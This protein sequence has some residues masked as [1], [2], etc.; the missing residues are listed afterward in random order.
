ME[1]I[2][3]NLTGLTPL[4]FPLDLGNN[5]DLGLNPNPDLESAM[6]LMGVLTPE[7]NV[8]IN[9]IIAEFI[10][11]DSS[12]LDTV[13]QQ[14]EIQGFSSVKS[15]SSLL[16]RDF[17]IGNDT[18]DSFLVNEPSS[19]D[20]L[21]GASLAQ[22]SAAKEIVF[23]DPTVEDY[24]S[25]MAGVTPGAEVI[26]LDATRDGV[27][28]IS[29][30][31]AQH[32]DIS[33]VHIVSHGGPGSLQLGAAELSLDNLDNY[34]H[35]LQSW[36]DSLTAEADI[37]F[38]GCDLAAGAVGTAFVQQLSHLTGADIAASNDLTGSAALGGDWNLEE[39]TGTIES[40]VV[41]QNGVML[42]YGSV[43]A[44]FTG[45]QTINSAT[46]NEDVVISGDVVLN[47]TGDFTIGNIGK[48][49]GDGT[50][51]LDN[52]TLK[53][54]GAVTIGGL[55]GGGGLLDLAIEATTINILED[56]T[57]SSRQVLGNDFLNSNSIANSGD[58]T[59][60]A[61]T[62]TLGSGAQLLAQV[63]PGSG[64]QAG[65]INLNAR[66]EKNT[67][68][69]DNLLGEIFNSTTVEAGVEINSATLLGNNITID[70]QANLTTLAEGRSDD[71]AID[72]VR[73][74]ANAQAQ[75]AITGNSR[76]E[77]SGNLTIT[78]DSKVDAKAL[79]EAKASGD[80]ALDAAISLSDIEN[81]AIAQISGNTTLSTTGDLQLSAKTD[82]KVETTADG[83]AGGGNAAGATVAVAT[84]ETVTEAYIDDSVSITKAANIGVAATA[85]EDFDTKATSTAGGASENSTDTQQRLQ[86][87]NAATSDGDISV[88][89]AFAIA[90]TNRRTKAYVATNGAITTD[91]TLEID[92]TS[93]TDS[94][95]QADATATDKNIGVGVAVGINRVEGLNEA[96]LGGTGTITAQE[97]DI[98]SKS[99]D[100]PSK[101]STEA[102]SGA[103]DTNVG[104]AGSLAL[105]LVNNNQS[106]ALLKDGVTLNEDGAN[107]NL[108]AENKAIYTAKALP[109]PEDNNSSKVGVGASVAVNVANNQTRAEVEDG[110][111]LNQAKDLTLK[112]TSEQEMNTTAEAGAEG[113]IAINPMAA[114]SFSDSETTARIGT[115]N[116]LNVTGDLNL[117]ATYQGKVETTAKGDTAGQDVGIGAAFALTEANDTTNATIARAIATEGEINLT[118][119][120][121]TDSNTTAN[122]SAKGGK[123]KDQD[124]PE[125][126]VDQQTQQQRSFG[127]S[128]KGQN[129]TQQTS[130]P[131]AATSDGTVSVAAAVGVNLVNSQTQATI[132]DGAIVTAGEELTL[133][134]NRDTNS[135]VKADGSA[136]GNTKVG[137]GAAVAINQVESV[138]EASIG[139]NAEVTAQGIT[140]ESGMAGDLGSSHNYS[141]EAISGAGDANIGVAGSLALNL[142]DSNQSQALLKDGSVVNGNG[143]NVNLTAENKAI[144]TAKAL[145]KSGN[146]S[147]KVGVGA[148]AAINVANNQTRAEVEDGASLNQAQDLTL[149]ANSDQEMNTTAE[150][151]SE[152]GIAI[153]PVAALSF[154]DSETTARVGT[155]NG[156]ELTG[157]LNLDAIYKGK[158]E[159][160]AKGDTAGQDV[161][162][163]AAFA[164][165]EANDTTNAT[166]ERAI[167]TEGEI[168]LTAQSVTDSNTTANAS[169]KGGEAEEQ[170]TPKDGVD[171]QTEQQRSFGN[172]QKSQN[173]TQQTSAPSA[174]TSEGTVSVAAAVGVNLINSQ[175]QAT[176]ADNT[177]VTAGE[178]VTLKANSNTNSK[179]KADGSAGGNTK[180]G[181]GAAVAINQVESLNEASIGD[182]AEV[183]AQ[184]ITIESGVGSSHNFT[185]EAISG[186]GAKNVGVAG[187][188]ALNDSQSQSLADIGT[189]AIIDGGGADV[190]ITANNNSKTKVNATSKSSGNSAGIGASVALNFTDDLTQAS[191][192]TNAELNNVGTLNLTANSSDEAETTAAGGAEGGV[193]I[194]AS[195]AVA[196]LNQTTQAAIASG[197]QITTQNGV[198]VSSTNTSKNTTKADGEAAGEDIGIG[199]SV[200]VVTTDSNTNAI[201]DRGISTIAGDLE[202]AATATRTYETESQAS[203][204]GASSDSDQSQSK[205]G[206]SLSEYDA[207][208]SNGSVDLAAAVAIADIDDDVTARIS[209]G[210]FAIEGDINLS[211]TNQADFTT[212]GK[213]AAEG[214]SG[215]VKVA[216][217]VGIN[218]TDNQTNT[219]LGQNTIIAQAQDI[220][221]SAVSQQ[222]VS[223]EF[224]NKLAVEAIS[225]ASDADSVGVAGSLAIAR[226]KDE[227][228]A[229]ISDGVI[230]A[231]AEDIKVESS[232][233]SRLSAQATA[234]TTGSEVGIGASVAILDTDRVNQ[235]FLGNNTIVNAN[236]LSVT[237]T[238]HRISPDK[239]EFT[240]FNNLA[241]DLQQ[242]LRTNNYY[243][244]AIAGGVNTDGGSAQI[245]G[246]FAVNKL[247]NR[248]ETWIGAGS[249][250]NTTGDLSLASSNDIQ[251][252]AIAGNIAGNLGGDVS[253]G[254]GSAD[255]LNTAIT[256]SF[257][258]T[259]VSI[260]A[261]NI[262]VNASSEQDLAAFGISI[263]AATGTLGIAG[264]ATVVTANNIT[265][266]FIADS[267]IDQPTTLI[268]S[269][270]LNV[271]AHSSFDLVNVAGGAAGGGDAGVG[272]ST[273][274]SDIDNTTKAYLGAFT[275]ANIAHNTNIQ[276][277]HTD[278]I[279]AIAAGG[280]VGGTAGIAGSATVTLLDN[281]T[282]AYVGEN[283]QINIDRTAAND[284]QSVIIHAFDNTKILGIGGALAGGGSVGFGVGV[285]VGIIN[286]NTQ[287]FV[288]DAAYVA[289]ENNIIVDAQSQE[290]ITSISASFAVGGTAGIGASVG[291]SKINLTTEAYIG[292][293][294]TVEAEG[295]VVVSA[296]DQTEIDAFAGGAAG[297]GTA[298]I[299]ASVIVPIVNKT[300]QAFIGSDASVSAKG[301]KDSIQVKNGQF[302]LNFI[303]NS[304]D[305]QDVSAPGF[306]FSDSDQQSDSQALNQQRVATAQTQAIKGLAVTATNQ[307]DLESYAITGGI[308]GNVAVTLSGNVNVLNNNTLAYIGDRAVINGDNANAGNDQSVLVAAGNDLYH[309]GITGSAAGAGGVGV[310]P[311]A[312]V[313]VFS[314]NTHA[315]IGQSAQVKAQKDINVVAEA[316][317]EILSVG[318]GLGIGGLAGVAGTVSV[319][320]LDNSTHAYIDNDANVQANG[321]VLV[322]ATNHTETDVIAGAAGVGLGVG[323]GASVGVV[324]ID[325][326]TK[327]Y[328]G[329]GASVDGKANTNTLMPVFGDQ[330]KSGISMDLIKGVAVQAESSEDV[331]T[332]TAAGGGGLYVGVAGAAT[333]NIID[334]NTTAYIGENAQINQDTAGA[335]NTQTVNVS[336]V[337]DLKLLG[338]GGSVAFGAGAFAGG[339]D[340]GIVENDTS[341]Y[342]GN[343][344]SVNA[345]QDIDVNAF[346]AKDVDGFAASGSVGLAGVAGSVAIHSIGAALDSDSQNSLNTQDQDDQ[347]DPTNPNAQSFV[348]DQVKVDQTVLPQLD[349]FSSVYAGDDSP[350]SKDNSQDIADAISDTRTDAAD[351]TPKNQVSNAVNQ[352]NVPGGTSAFI[353]SGAVVNAGEDIGIRAKENLDFDVTVGS[354]AVGIV[355]FGGSVAVTNIAENTQAYIDNSATVAAGDDITVATQFNETLDGQGFVG[356]GGLV[357]LGAQV[358][359]FNEKSNQAAYIDDGAN[360]SQADTLQVTAD[361]EQTL[362]AESTGASA[363]LGFAAGAAIARAN[364]EGSTRAY[365]GDVNIG[366]GN[367]TVNDINIAA[368]STVSSEATTLAVAAGIGGSL[369]GASA[370]SKV[371]P[372]I[373]A[374]IGNGA[375]IAVANDINILSTSKT[376]T[377]TEAKGLSLGGVSIGVSES[378]ATMTPEVNAAIGQNANID[379]GGNIVIQAIHNEGGEAAFAKANPS[380]GSIGLSAIG[381]NAKAEANANVSATVGAGTTI[382]T[383][384]DLALSANG[385]NK[386]ITNVEGFS[387]AI[388]GSVGFTSAIANAGGTVEA[389]MD[390]A[391]IQAKN[392]SVSA[393]AV[394]LSETNNK[395]FTAAAISGRNPVVEA[396]TTTT[397]N[398]SIGDGINSTDITTT[399]NVIVQANAQTDAG[400]TG[401]GK[402]GGLIDV[403]VVEVETTRKATVSAAI[404]PE[405]SINAGGDIDVQS[406]HGQEVEV[407]DGT[408]DLA[409]VDNNANNPDTITLTQNHGLISGD[410]IVYN[411]NGG[412]SIGGLENERTYSVIRID[413]Q[414]VRLGAE[415]TGAQIDDAKDT[416]TFVQ[417]HAFVT[418]DQVVYDNGSGATLGGLVSGQTYFLRVIDETTIKLTETLQGATLDPRNF[419]PST[420]INSAL[421]VNNHGF[422]TGDALTYRAPEPDNFFAANQIDYNSNIIDIGEGITGDD[423]PT[424]NFNTGDAILYETDIEPIGGLINGQTYYIVRINDSKFQLAASLADA[425]AEDNNGNPQP[426]VIDLTESDLPGNQFI[427]ASSKRP[428]TGL[429][430]GN[431]YYAVQ[432]N[433][434]QLRLA[435]TQQDALLGN[436]INLDTTGLTV[437]H[438]IGLEGVDLNTSDIS[439]NDAFSIYHELDRS[440]ANGANHQ[441]EGAGGA[442]ALANAPGGNGI[443]KAVADSSSGNIFGASNAETKVSSTVNTGTTIGDGVTL[444]GNNITIGA[445]SFNLATATSRNFA[446]GLGTGGNG[447][448]DV[449]VDN[450]SK[451]TIGEKAA[452]QAR[453]TFKLS[454]QASQDLSSSSEAKGVGGIG[455]ALSNNKLNLDYQSLASV[456]KDAQIQTKAQNLDTPTEGDLVIEALTTDTN[457][458][459][460]VSSL[461]AGAGGGSN[462]FINFSNGSSLTQVKVD[463]GA[464]LVGNTVTLKSQTKNLN[465]NLNSKATAG[466]IGAG[467]EVE[468][469]FNFDNARSEV[470]LEN[471]ASVSGL[472]EVNLSALNDNIASK[473]KAKGEVFAFAGGGNVKA[474]NQQDLSAKVFTNPGSKIKTPKLLVEAKTNT[475]GDNHITEPDKREAGP[476]VFIDEN[477]SESLNYDRTI[478][479]NSIL[480]AEPDPEL[481]IN[482]HGEVICAHNVDIID[483]DG[484]TLGL[485]EAE[486]IIVNDILNDDLMEATFS[487]SDLPEN[488]GVGVIKGNPR[489][490]ENYDS[491]TIINHSEKDL[492]INDIDVI[493][494]TVPTIMIEGAKPGERKDVFEKDPKD[495]KDIIKL[496]RLLAPTLIDIQNHSDSDVILN[497]LIENPHDTTRIVNTGGNILSTGPDAVIETRAL[498][499][500]S[501]QGGIGTIDD[502]INARLIQNYATGEGFGLSNDKL[503]DPTLPL[504]TS[505]NASAEEA[506]YLDLQGILRDDQPLTINAGLISSETEDVDLKIQQGIDGNGQ[507]QTSTYDFDLI[508][509][510]GD[511]IIDAGDSDTNLIGNTDILANGQL[512]VITGN[513]IDLTEIN[514]RL[515]V[516]R[517]TSA[518]GD[519]RLTVAD[520]Q[521][522][523]EDLIM[524][525]GATITALD[526]SV[527]LLSGDDIHLGP[528][529]TIQA[530]EEVFIQGDYGDADTGV[531]S[532]IAI[533]GAIANNSEV[534]EFAGGNDNDTITLPGN[535]GN[536]LVNL[537]GGNDS[538]NGGNGKDTVFGGTGDDLLLGNLGND[539]LDGQQGNDFLDGQQGDDQLMGGAGD[540]DLNGSQGEDIL[541]GGIGN[542]ALNG[543]VDNDLLLGAADD[544]TIEGG[545]GNDI[546]MGGEGND[547]LAGDAG[548][549]ELHGGDGIDLLLG[550]LGADNLYGEAG[551]DDLDG[552]KGDDLLDGGIG[553]DA[554]Y[555]AEGNDQLNGSDG[556]D[557]LEGGIGKNILDGGE[558]FDWLEVDA[559]DEVLNSTDEDIVNVNG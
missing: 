212:K 256:R 397:T 449:S 81:S 243:T 480:S 242:L 523:G 126:G 86:E 345:Q 280:A 137:V 236:S 229:W 511:I 24:Q 213:G 29:E 493:N 40:A 170:D 98:A 37:L 309:M 334:S 355:G 377:R 223:E 50:G 538:F 107:I 495:P 106:Q 333:V 405:V 231:A 268:A 315:Y 233:T 393:N 521:A 85:L 6:N 303:E 291:V 115:G 131:S 109:K 455:I 183:T 255:I 168:N 165:T 134:A 273:A 294:A 78:A 510:G 390:G 71:V 152:G 551:D 10:Q 539:L 422:Q 312:G 30:V 82:T 413:D 351:N 407:N 336:A 53:V 139:N 4:Q 399:G 316:Q 218:T 77:S 274:I 375:N 415:F 380:A 133:Q 84:I 372:T 406:T 402:G 314:N 319:I 108:T 330:D 60:N 194:D 248:I 537:G 518:F 534:V 35:T 442:L 192:G 18:T 191:V 374:A 269:G 217:G 468:S 250:I 190:T 166:I 430:D 419:T 113:G 392:L 189:G 446:G 435:A 512:D 174:A 59:F 525:D 508:R 431:T 228:K 33:G 16:G 543:G 428:I 391:V 322:S 535:Y 459:S 11:E 483:T 155:G 547:V 519:I 156:I 21:T 401:S 221:I 20:S 481:I 448:T 262:Q 234:K 100:T 554:L 238:N 389:T 203:S 421:T 337:N 75:V 559:D 110:A 463:S 403:G 193:A 230:I 266:A 79:T 122:A 249:V 460:K 505:L 497:G 451:A 379:A 531:G 239:F 347:Q 56:V 324:L 104:V 210:I 150:A 545:D 513:N 195:V 272:L 343:G 17:L 68:G 227:T 47:V 284:N 9:P 418:G 456:G 320:S 382:N 132:A 370:K 292:S 444:A 304:D 186:A 169:A 470:R 275:Q 171:Q 427:T 411:N 548:E 423:K 93:S 225:G 145:S 19:Y 267:T 496:P 128:Q 7:L 433:G 307:D 354:G 302:G 83:T 38:Y 542:D 185:T 295:N 328:I 373:E 289:A 74:E 286:K 58:L 376:Q 358:V 95:V 42:S 197:K 501:N 532:N 484:E 87:N 136:G 425:T 443:A 396:T 271:T 327:A 313:A 36:A 34:A 296:D 350:D 288:A 352:T 119:Q 209:N 472:N 265:E 318:I 514:G 526:G 8:P 241:D 507:P 367:G 464:D 331:F 544:D 378:I 260:N 462:A 494:K 187:A 429:I 546:L 117:E 28:Q 123:A 141:A 436:Y 92:A 342:L 364:V 232:D 499:L 285:D 365:L 154:S 252:K 536:S 522:T 13:F 2:A 49:V 235:A 366:Q 52:L 558:G 32:Q 180:V 555:G 240:D 159:T 361:A 198:N 517:A 339:V 473:V 458:N 130:A 515:D 149:K 287:A 158:V 162:I 487:I 475:S 332:V 368:N 41:F 114:L 395:V 502:R 14:E 530:T 176:I 471:N 461:G 414:T 144:H 321:N 224:K 94:S 450:K 103:G 465:V 491:V 254:L 369:V 39:T 310:A 387:G 349:L 206:E 91:D 73:V 424:H 143:A 23:I 326:D 173:N 516:R 346:S 467:V 142:V 196:D 63:E 400:A 323:I 381:A 283:A 412:N 529:A 356:T 127:N 550:G 112:A 416:I 348:D 247:N 219:L 88:A 325:K 301:L 498:E 202:V 64:F 244:E 276:A 161:A 503:L 43:L 124:T 290:D 305:N 476:F 61:S 438:S 261:N 408:F 15:N 297:G 125:D 72:G 140:I 452:I 80:T 479:F 65:N 398:A 111:N 279:L 57:I 469:N 200:T 181:V 278:D 116:G 51:P 482:A 215:S 199:A 394:G 178:E 300:T 299:G 175:A 118:A 184:G 253:V 26:L 340:I 541:D 277:T 485:V 388:L 384:G 148:S 474:M 524:R 67:T 329:Q 44:S 486:D 129:N 89:A 237:A 96:Y 70:S 160:T 135:T 167:A 386:A 246:S 308:A 66:E 45:N 105:N 55:I 441:L 151:G 477:K 466:G 306:D 341:A 492:I 426:K 335:G 409:N 478:D 549:D 439:E 164:L 489:F 359:I 363:G 207:S 245:A 357:S 201:V 447:D 97:I 1:F 420:V 22:P 121:V 258:E 69:G 404:N 172:S 163:G 445:T 553:N 146:D 293:N 263:A 216:V 211:A 99:G 3:E 214:N 383:D 311:A 457:V 504:D 432:V 528:S 506:V 344:A 48:I 362:K 259:G 552:G 157:D 509:A 257:I 90:N 410:Q 27:T 12:F 31:L 298:A 264:V 434:N 317:E 138:N 177:T 454:S 46:F 222:N 182:N 102:I 437:E 282:L 188:L 54:D 533:L 179:V 556:D 385:S 270:N 205:S 353:G 500:V 417:P 488:I 540:D 360:I 153:N 76:I 204:K 520:S 208:T 220:N 147:S 453:G 371:N 338:A 226:S 440:D 25:L 490:Q 281:Q 5:T 527:T 557:Y 120:S 251:S 62:I 101:F